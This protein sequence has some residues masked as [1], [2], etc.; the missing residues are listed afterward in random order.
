[1]KLLEHLNWRY[2]TKKFDA[3]KKL[4]EN[5]LEY[6][7]EAIR[8]S[9][10][11]YGL[12]LYKVLIV[13]NA[14]VREQLKPVSWGQQQITDC[15]HLFVFCNYTD[16]TPEHVDAYIDLVAAERGIAKESLTGYGDFMQSKI[17]E[18]SE[19]E[20][21][22][23][24][25]R[26]PYIALMNLLTACAELG[27]DACPMEGFEPEEYNRILHL[28]KQGLNACV[29]APVGFRHAEDHTQ[30]AEKIRKPVKEL[31]GFVK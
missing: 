22:N 2:A 18:K 13:E 8:L 27:I 17:N 1:M 28:D 5:E 11:S 7:M 23:W 26:Q 19:A 14:Q 20:K 24:L 15:S 6:L 25:E 29:I 9:P 21:K 12:Q 31:F 4:S 3:G 16:A 10:S 30:H